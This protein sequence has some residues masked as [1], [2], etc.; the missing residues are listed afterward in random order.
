MQDVIFAQ[1]FAA[2]VQRRSHHKK[3]PGSF[4]PGVLLDGV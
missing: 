2:L 3:T 1:R 4:L